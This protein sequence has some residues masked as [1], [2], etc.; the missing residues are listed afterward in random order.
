MEHA[1]QDENRVSRSVV[2]E[3]PWPPSL[4][5]YW[6]RAGTH[7]HI[8]NEGRS[9]RQAVAWAAR[10]HCS[11]GR[12]RVAVEIQA[13]PPDSRRR[14]LDNT[15]KVVCDGLQAGRL[16]EDDSQIDDLRIVRGPMRK[17]EGAILVT[18]SQA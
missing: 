9:Y 15:L 17:G 4:N 10:L 12:Q 14:D 6:R 1:S 2:L 5:R 8:S 3:L 16:I 11:F 13:F 18:V 7:M